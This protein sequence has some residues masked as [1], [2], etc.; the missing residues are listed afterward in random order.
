MSLAEFDHIQVALPWQQDQWQGLLSRH[1]EGRLPH[2]LLLRGEPGTGKNRFALALAQYLLCAQPVAG[3]ACGDCKRCQLNLAGSHPDLNLLEPEEPGRAI[4][5]DQVRAVVDFVS[6]KAQLD[7]YRILLL[8][9]A[10]AMN[11]SASN[12]LLKSLE[13]PGERTL[14]ILVTHQVSQVLPTIR[15]RCQV[16]QFPVPERQQALQWLAPLVGDSG[17]AEKLLNVASGAPLRA[18]QLDQS[19]WLGERN[20]VL[21]QW[22]A[23]LQG[24]R[25]PVRTAEGW[26]QYP[27]LELTTWLLGWQIDLARLMA[28]MDTINNR[29]LQPQLQ[30]A[31]ALVNPQRLFASHD[32]LLRVRQMLVSQA[33]PNLPLLLEEILL[34]WSQVRSP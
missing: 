1:R 11:P 32:H 34:K 27:I 26:G 20:T 23:V 29:D 5:V 30:T 22:L 28:G 8:S 15:S 17:K 12:A 25:D 9:P 33:N 3:S 24:K 4:K 16:L 7:G 2:A 13:E 31:S 10:E 18:L 21:Q 19:Q 6:K 14:L